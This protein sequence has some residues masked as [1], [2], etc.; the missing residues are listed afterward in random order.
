M[1]RG[2]FVFFCGGLF[3]LG[4]VVSGMTDTRKVVGWL[5]VFGDWD[6]TLAFVMAGAIL[7]MALAWRVAARRDRAIFGRA[8]PHPR[9]FDAGARV[10]ARLVAGS[11]LFGAGWGLAGACPGTA[12][13]MLGEG[14]LG[15]GFTIVGLVLGTYI[16]GVWQSRPSGEV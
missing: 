8:M 11:L 3:G 2:G 1:R 15:A 6:P 4:L 10:D 5:D 12:L 16:Y 13:A 14:K 9:R 7:P